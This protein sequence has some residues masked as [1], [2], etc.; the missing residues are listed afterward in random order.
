MEQPPSPEQHNIPPLHETLPAELG[1]IETEELRDARE[2]MRAAIRQDNPDEV[3]RLRILYKTLAEQVVEQVDDK[4]HYEAE[5]GRIVAE[6][7]LWYE[8][9][10]INNY[11]DDI[12]AAID[13]ARNLHLYGLVE[14]LRSSVDKYYLD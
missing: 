4:L 1:F 7:S 5:I 2:F 13:Y 8:A 3:R 6:A 9:G 12:E 11:L 10:D 14:R